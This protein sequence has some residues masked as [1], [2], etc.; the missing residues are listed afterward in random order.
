[1]F[2][3]FYAVYSWFHFGCFSSHLIMG[4]CHQDDTCLF[5]QITP[6]NSKILKR[7]WNQQSHSSRIPYFITYFS[8]NTHRLS[9][10]H[11]ALRKNE[12]KLK[13]HL[14]W[15]VSR[16][17]ALVCREIWFTGRKCENFKG[18]G[19]FHLCSNTWN[20]ESETPSTNQRRK[21]WKLHIQNVN[22]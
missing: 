8:H 7:R 13:R 16:W 22:W 20:K 19:G 2:H 4:I 21:S 11:Y 10:V 15:L 12:N 18:L 6:Q 17:I 5:T 9:S 14:A 1:M 3:D